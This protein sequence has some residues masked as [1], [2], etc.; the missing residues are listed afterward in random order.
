MTDMKCTWLVWPESPPCG[1]TARVVYKKP[2]PRRGPREPKTL[3][4]P[5]CGLHDTTAA[6]QEAPQQGFEREVLES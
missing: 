5:R 3:R 6:Q 1:K 2:N 4:Y